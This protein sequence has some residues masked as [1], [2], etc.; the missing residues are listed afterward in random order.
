VTTALFVFGYPTSIVVLTRWLPVVRERRIRWFVV[1]E[2]AVA[3]IVAGWIIKRDSMSAVIN[4]SWLV[5]AAV[6]YAAAGRRRR[7]TSGS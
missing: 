5:I 7:A 2:V 1:H 4:G 6:W 3:A